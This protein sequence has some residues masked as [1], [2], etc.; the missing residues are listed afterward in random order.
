MKKAIPTGGNLR[1]D[2]GGRYLLT[3]VA[4]AIKEPHHAAY[5][6]TQALIENCPSL[7][8]EFSQ[9]TAHASRG[10]HWLTSYRLTAAGLYAFLGWIEARRASR[11]LF[12]VLFPAQVRESGGELSDVKARQSQ[13]KGYAALLERP[14]PDTKNRPCKLAEKPQILCTTEQIEKPMAIAFREAQANKKTDKK[15]GV[16]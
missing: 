4:E 12:G 7:A 1:K 16:R 13:L 6:A 9:V 14:S 11:L 3:D 8:N 10:G 15:K 5:K 2:K